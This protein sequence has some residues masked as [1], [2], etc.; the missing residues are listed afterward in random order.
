MLSAS[1][2]TQVTQ[3][4]RIRK[5]QTRQNKKRSD[6]LS[7]CMAAGSFIMAAI[8]LPAPPAFGHSRLE[9]LAVWQ[10]RWWQSRVW[11][12]AICWQA[13]TCTSM[14]ASIYVMCVCMDGW[15][16]GWMD[17][18]MDR[19][20]MLDAW[21]D[22]GKDGWMCMCIYIRTYAYVWCDCPW[23]GVTERTLA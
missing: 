10:M 16:D 8:G 23:R 17:E 9:V 19:C 1:S 15:M 22:G 7:S 18:R 3:A 14:C 4:S 6:P 12:L 5:T 11:R 20:W 2:K 21:M 13:C